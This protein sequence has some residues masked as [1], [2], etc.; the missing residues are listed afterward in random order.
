ML[1]FMEIQMQDEWYSRKTLDGKGDY[2][3]V[4][5]QNE[6]V[7]GQNTE[8]S[9][10]KGIKQFKENSKG[11]QPP[12]VCY[13][14]HY[15]HGNGSGFSTGE[16]YLGCCVQCWAP[17]YKGDMNIL[18]QVQQRAEMMIRGVEHLSHMERLREL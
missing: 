9:L 16:I 6:R 3:E 4:K 11:H 1:H 13:A 5:Q 10:G 8:D 7:S 12:G 2:R 15:Q 18:G 14:E 17:M